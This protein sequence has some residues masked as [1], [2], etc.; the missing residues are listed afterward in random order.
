MTIE[1]NLRPSPVSATTPTMMPAPAQVAP[2]LSMPIAPP[3]IALAKPEFRT[4]SLTEP[5]PRKR[6]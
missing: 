5:L 2:T 1:L 4:W 6:S 3:S